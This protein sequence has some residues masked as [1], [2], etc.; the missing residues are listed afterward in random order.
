V[1][2]DGWLDDDDAQ[3]HVAAKLGRLR[4]I[5]IKLHR[6]LEGTPVTAHLVLRADNHWD[7]RI[8]CKTTPADACGEAHPAQAACDHPTM[9]LGVGL[10]VFWPTRMPG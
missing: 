2:R 6:P 10:K 5:T 9:G 8:V 4:T 3:L 7:A 1:S